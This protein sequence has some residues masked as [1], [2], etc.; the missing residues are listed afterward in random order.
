M[1]LMSDAFPTTSHAHLTSNVNLGASRMRLGCICKKSKT[2]LRI[3]LIVAISACMF[4]RCADVLGMFRNV[5]KHRY[6]SWHD[7]VYV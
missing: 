6:F 2:V 4:P 3:V 7:N 1:H 5:L